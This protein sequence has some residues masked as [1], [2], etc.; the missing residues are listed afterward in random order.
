MLDATP[1]EGWEAGKLK[2][3]SNYGG[4]TEGQ[5]IHA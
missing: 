3:P 4:M 1:L 5:P 2:T